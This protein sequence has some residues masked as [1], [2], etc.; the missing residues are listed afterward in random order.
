MQRMVEAFN[1]G[2]AGRGPAAE[3]SFFPDFQYAE[4]LSIAA[5]GGDMPDAFELDGPLVA[6]FVDARLLAPL[7]GVL[8][9]EQLADFLPSVIVQGT[10]GETLYA[11]GAFESAAVLYF[12]R[13]MLEQAGIELPSAQQSW[14]FPTLLAACEKL[15][16]RGRLAL[17]MHMNETSDEWFSY[18]FAPVIWSGGGALIDAQGLNVRGVLASASNVHSLEAWQALFRRGY[19]LADPINPDP[20]G[21]GTTAMDWNGHWMLHSHAAKKGASLGVMPLPRL[22]RL[23]VAPCGS[24]CWGISTSS[25][26]PAAAA[27]WLRWVTAPS[28]GILPLVRA[29]GAIP[30]RRSAFAL[31]PEYAAPPYSLLRQQLEHTAR[32]RPRTPFYST[33]TSRFAAALRD[34]AHGANVASRLATAEDEVARV[35][36]RRARARP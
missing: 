13:R 3:A 35:I 31:F 27:E 36:E 25:A 28:T 15:R 21:S 20:F 26:Q 4:K 11:L 19:A 18:A 33:L 9:A 7:V 16:Q 5:A 17:A 30:A 2:L 23:P 14:D 12:D 34:I 29:N 6:R 24:W 1:H 22:G 32:P 8:D 10:I